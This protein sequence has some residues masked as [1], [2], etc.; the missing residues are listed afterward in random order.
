MSRGIPLR[1]EGRLPWLE[2]LKNLVLDCLARDEP[3]SYWTIWKVAPN[4]L[5]GLL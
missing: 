3:G 4:S 5:L 2:G 1:D